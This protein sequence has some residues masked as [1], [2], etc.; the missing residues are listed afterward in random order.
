[1]H[2]ALMLLRAKNGVIKIRVLL[3]IT[4]YNVRRSFVVTNILL[5]RNIDCEM[6][7]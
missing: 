6:Y 4:T 2:C 1:M 5:M 7:D 3:L